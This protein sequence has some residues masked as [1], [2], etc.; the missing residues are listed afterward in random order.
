[1]DLTDLTDLTFV[2]PNYGSSYSRKETV[3]LLSY[4]VCLWMNL[5]SQRVTH[6]SVPP[7]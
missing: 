6:K 5:V 4:M 1:M 7:L 2:V 3:H